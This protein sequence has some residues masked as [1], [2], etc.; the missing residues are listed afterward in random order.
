MELPAPAQ[1]RRYLAAGALVAGLTMLAALPSAA[2]PDMAAAFKR[3]DANS[4]GALTVEEF[5]ASA[6]DVKRMN[7]RKV[8][9]G[10]TSARRRR[11]LP[12]RR[13]SF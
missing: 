12:R 9:R 5:S 11:I 1:R 8:E 4:D 6:S 3:L 2:Q 7:L 13:S 10:A